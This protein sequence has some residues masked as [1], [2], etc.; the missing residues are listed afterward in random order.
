[1]PLQQ[2]HINVRQIKIPIT[3]M[4]CWILFSNHITWEA[5][6]VPNNLR[7]TLLHAV[8]TVSSIRLRNC[9]MKCLPILKKWHLYIISNHF[10]RNGL[11]LNPTVS[12]VSY[13]RYTMYKYFFHISHFYWLVIHEI[14]FFIYIIT[15]LCFSQLTSYT[16]LLIA[17]TICFNFLMCVLNLFSFHQPPV[18][19]H[20][21]SITPVA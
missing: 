14:S 18:Y 4:W 17:D 12:L 6:F 21:S 3:L 15:Y 11:N 8:Y 19:N 9:G 7:W 2:R 13:V 10:Y 1:M 5:A 20:P 16:I